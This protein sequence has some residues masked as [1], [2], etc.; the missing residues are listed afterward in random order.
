M[1]RKG[2]FMRMLA[3]ALALAASSAVAGCGP[4]VECQAP[5]TTSDCADAVRRAQAAL[6][7]HPDWIP[8]DARP[9][10]LTLVWDACQDADCAEE[11]DG[12]EFVRIVDANDQR[13]GRVIVC[14]EDALCGDQDAVIGFP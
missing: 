11:L 13:L 5:L 9:T 3:W 14:I 10:E 12:F 1:L 8:D 6:A 4:A 7:Q 2:A